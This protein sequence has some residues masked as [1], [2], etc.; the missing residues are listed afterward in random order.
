M[1][2]P[3]RALG[4]GRLGSPRRR[5]RRAGARGEREVAEHEAQ[6]RRRGARST[7][8]QDALG[9][10]AVRA[11]EVA[12]HHELEVGAGAAAHVVAVV[13][14]LGQ[15][16]A[17]GRIVGSARRERPR[18]P[19]RAAARGGGARAAS[20]TS[21][22]VPYPIVLVL[23]GLAIGLH[24]RAARPGAR[25]RTSSSS[26]SC[27]RCWSPP[28][29]TPRRRSCAPSAGRWRYLALGAGAGHDGRGRRRRPRAGRR[30][31]VGRRVR[32]RRRRRADGPGRGAG[33]LQAR[34]RARARAAGRRGRG[35]AQRRDARWSRS[36]SRVGVA[37]GGDASTSPT[38]PATSSVSAAGGIAHRPRRRL[39]DLG[40]RS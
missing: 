23:G 28:A 5:A 40:R 25:R 15:R 12:V 31:A 11:L 35:D 17:I 4:G 9:G 3:E 1:H 14:G 37:T 36:G 8:A 2:L 6:A 32:A 27:R 22:A 39:A 29:T 7:R 10:G 19:V 16:S 38:P 13:D 33:D 20:R 26:S 21:C 34:A 30:A 24:P 18:V